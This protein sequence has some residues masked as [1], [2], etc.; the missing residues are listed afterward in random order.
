[1]V[2]YCVDLSLSLSLWQIESLR[3]ALGF[4]QDENFRLKAQIA[5]VSGPFVTAITLLFAL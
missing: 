2:I 4:S 1:M 3:K 5:K